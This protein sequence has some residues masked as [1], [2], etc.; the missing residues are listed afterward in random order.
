MQT[1]A[2]FIYPWPTRNPFHTFHERRLTHAESQSIVIVCTAHVWW[3][4]KY[5]LNHTYCIEYQSIATLS[6]FNLIHNYTNVR[7]VHM[8]HTFHE[9]RLTHAE[10][11]SI[12]IAVY[13]W[14][15]ITWER[16]DDVIIKFWYYNTCAGGTK[17]SLWKCQWRK[18]RPRRPRGAGGRRP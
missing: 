7:A 6:S 17:F 10:S 16:N 15:Y 9:R 3:G 5:D 1:Y 2:L 12:V 8:S 4:W 14:T 13:F 18:Y 11:Q